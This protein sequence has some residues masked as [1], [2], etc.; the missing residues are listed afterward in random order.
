MDVLATSGFS[1]VYSLR[2]SVRQ[3]FNPR[4]AGT[5]SLPGLWF[6]GFSLGGL[7]M[8][9]FAFSV[10]SLSSSFSHPSHQ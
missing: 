5:R 8:V 3:R 2:S 9:L 1:T 10:S 4:N 6:S 7:G